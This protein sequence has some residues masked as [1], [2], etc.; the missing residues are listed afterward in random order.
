MNH[1]APPVA[2][3]IASELSDFSELWRTIVRYRWNVAGVMAALLLVGILHAFSIE[4]TYRAT[5]TVLIEN[6][7]N[8]AV[9]VQ[10]VYD[11]GYGAREYLSTQ[12][13]LLRSRE[14]SGRVVDK[15]DLTNNTEIL[16]PAEEPSWW[17]LLRA[18]RWPELLP[19]VESEAPADAVEPPEA[20]RER[21]I[22]VLQK[23]LAVEPVVTTQLMRVHVETRSPA[24]STMLANALGDLYVESGLESR[25]EATERATR[26]L[27]VRLADLRTK[28]E[29]SERALQDYRERHQLVNV[30]GSRGLVEE[31][32]VDNARKLREAQRKKTEL[33]SSY[34]KIQQAGGDEQKLQE[35]SNLLLD[36]LVQKASDNLSQAQQSVK[37][38][39]DRYGEKH[40]QMAAAQARFAAAKRAYYEQLRLAANGIKAEYEIAAETERALVNVVS[41]TKGQIRKLDQRDFELKGLERE[42]ETN[43]E[44]YEL[45][46]KRFKETDTASTYEPLNARIVDRAVQPQAPFRPNKSKIVML[47]AL[48]GALLGLMLAALRHVLTQSIQSPDHLE[49]LTQLPVIS[50]LPPVSGLGKTLSAPQMCMQ[51]PRAPFSEGVR[52]IRASLHLS[53]VDKR[54][55]KVMFTSAVPREGKSSIASSFAAVLGHTERVVLIEADLRAPSLKKIF[56]IAKEAP[57]VVELLSGQATLEQALHRDADSGIHVLPVGQIPANPAEVVASAAFGKLVDILAAQYD[58]VVIDTPPCGVA[59]DSALLAQRMDAVLFVVHGG[60]TGARTVQTAIKQLRSAQAPLLGHILNQVDARS[61][62]GYDGRYYLYGSYG[63]QG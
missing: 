40:P 10:E 44:L 49:Q 41:S 25:L 42:V 58:R 18:G 33:A 29:A 35:I 26:W 5:V 4:P 13:E 34:W 31:E 3:L 24:L 53:D 21:A 59:S 45:F 61:A 23:L 22:S 62:Y 14:L 32:L 55:R 39:E 12:F 52:S 54:M 11:P 43:R 46:L 37:Q 1:P 56:G 57:G 38:L 30:G 27:T 63:S 16:P 28:L 60:T 17:Q 51:Q 36:P 8:H 15:L 20:R 9:Q 6:R 2:P 48:A 47:W 7:P 19:F 50:V